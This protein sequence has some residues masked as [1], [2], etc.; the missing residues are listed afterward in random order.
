MVST[1]KTFE[2]QFLITLPFRAHF[3]GPEFKQ[4]SMVS[5]CFIMVCLNRAGLQQVFALVYVQV[6]LQLYF[7]Q[8]GS[9]LFVLKIISFCC[10]LQASRFSRNITYSTWSLP[11]NWRNFTNCER[12][13]GLICS[14]SLLIYKRFF[15]GN[16]AHAVWE[17]R[18]TTSRPTS[19]YHGNTPCYMSGDCRSIHESSL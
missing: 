3:S 6:S 15:K 2:R 17:T 5:N 14:R 19:C 7:Q 11:D 4:Q 1:S 16:P 18:I 9:V 12:L 8:Y 13:K 10:L